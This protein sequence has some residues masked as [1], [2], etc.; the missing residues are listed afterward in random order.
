MCHEQEEDLDS[1]F[2]SLT[3]VVAM[4]AFE[5]HGLEDQDASDDN[6]YDWLYSDPFLTNFPTCR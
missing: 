3:E 6:F 4:K 2:E 5:L 1:I